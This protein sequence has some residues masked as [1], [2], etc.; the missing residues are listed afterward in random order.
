MVLEKIYTELYHIGKPIDVLNA[1]EWLDNHPEV[2]DIN[3]DIINKVRK[4]ELNL[5]LLI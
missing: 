1:L 2:A 5:D 4:S 3:S